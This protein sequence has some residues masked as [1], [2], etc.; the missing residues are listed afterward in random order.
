MIV[1]PLPNDIIQ[2]KDGAKM[3]V[4]GFNN[5][6]SKGPAVFCHQEGDDPM[7]KQL[8]TIYFFDIEKI[9][10]V[11]VEFSSSTKVFSAMGRIKRKIHLPQPHDEI[12]VIDK[13]SEKDED[14]KST[15]K[16][17]K[18][19][20]YKLHSKK[21]GISK[22]LIVEDDDGNGYMIDEIIDV[23]RDMGSADFNQRQFIRLYKEYTGHR[24]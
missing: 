8:I 20:G 18:V 19:S 23:K 1:L 14:G 21:Y 2:T 5:Y 11:R 24:V 12:T 9:N 22:G 15:T 4:A 13:E 17:V 3:H 6:K 10:D 16:S 7:S